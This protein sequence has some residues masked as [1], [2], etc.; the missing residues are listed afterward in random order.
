[1]EQKRKFRLSGLAA[2]LVNGCFGGGG[3]V[4]LL[5]LLTKWCGVEE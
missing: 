3:G 4:P 2:G 1:M 5:V